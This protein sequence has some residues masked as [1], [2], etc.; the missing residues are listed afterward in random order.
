METKQNYCQC[1]VANSR[2]TFKAAFYG[3]R[4]LSC[5]NCYGA[6]KVVLR[7]L[8]WKDYKRLQYDVRSRSCC[9]FEF[10]MHYQGDA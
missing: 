7:A 9:I 4:R 3:H 8:P 5:N 10:V 6:I 1:R 2:P